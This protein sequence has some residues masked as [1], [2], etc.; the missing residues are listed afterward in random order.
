MIK[1]KKL[2]IVI[3]MMLSLTLVMAGCGGGSTDTGDTG[4]A[5]DTDEIK[6]EEIDKEAVVAKLTPPAGGEFEFV[7]LET[8]EGITFIDIHAEDRVAKELVEWYTEALAG[9][10]F[11]NEEDIIAAEEEARLAEKEKKAEEGGYELEGPPEPEADQGEYEQSEIMMSETITGFIKGN[12]ISIMITQSGFK[13]DGKYS[14]KYNA[15]V[16]ISWPD[17][18]DAAVTDAAVTGD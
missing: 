2:S 1:N 11:I 16:M 10:D 8:V 9:M 15:E 13:L 18:L 3:A 7:D 6:V 17:D 5:A 12:K 4:E 14:G